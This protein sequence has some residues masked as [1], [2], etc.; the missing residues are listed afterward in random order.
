MNATTYTAMWVE[1]NMRMA[2]AYLLWPEA[3]N[4]QTARKHAKAVIDHFG[5][6][7]ED[8]GQVPTRMGDVHWRQLARLRAAQ[9]YIWEIKESWKDPERSANLTAAFD[10]LDD[11][12][13]SQFWE[14]THRAEWYEQYGDCR[15]M[16][17]R[18]EFDVTKRLALYDRARSDYIKARDLAEGYPKGTYD[19]DVRPASITDKLATLHE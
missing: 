8:H 16:I 10:L 14:H 18:M 15:A 4:V 17:A 9:S 19:R 5:A 7:P 2:D 3:R 6:L 13:P 12:K 11:I 1:A